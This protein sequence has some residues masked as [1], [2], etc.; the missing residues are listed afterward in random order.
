MN[1]D[2]FDAR[3]RDLQNRNIT[4]TSKTPPKTAYF[5][6]KDNNEEMPLLKPVMK[7]FHCTEASVGEG[8]DST[9]ASPQGELLQQQQQ[10]PKPELGGS[11]EASMVCNGQ[12]R[13][14]GRPNVE[15][16][17]GGMDRFTMQSYSCLSGTVGVVETKAAKNGDDVIGGGGGGLTVKANAKADQCWLTS[18]GEGADWR[19]AFEE[20]GGKGVVEEQGEKGMVEEQGGK[21]VVEEQG[22]KGV[23]EEKDVALLGEDSVRAPTERGT[24][25]FTQSTD[26]A[27][28]GV[29]EAGICEEED[30][31]QR[32]VPCMLLLDSTK[33]HRSH[34]VFK[35]VR[36]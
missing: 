31:G 6:E 28:I 4:D 10:E 26:A 1:P 20:Q 12:T 15:K 30:V 16:E 18:S 34:D 23:V 33:G 5:T 9:W 13:N 27:P 8:K 7:G 17:K 14:D 3:Q 32:L 22:G 25:L 19:E 36:K 21:G 2:R 24:E 11:S 35:G 29:G